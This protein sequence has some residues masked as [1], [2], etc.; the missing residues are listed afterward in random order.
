MEWTD[1]G[2]SICNDVVYNQRLS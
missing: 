1:S 2:F